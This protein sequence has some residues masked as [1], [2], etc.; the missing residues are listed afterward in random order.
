MTSD[1]TKHKAKTSHFVGIQNIT[2]IKNKSWFFHFVLLNSFERSPPLQ[3][4]IENQ[5][6]LELRLV[7][8]VNRLQISRK[9]WV[10]Q[11]TIRRPPDAVELVAAGQRQL[12]PWEADAAR[13]IHRRL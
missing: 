6:N 5:L 2:S 10:A 7:D 1:R 9:L 8:V 4:E 11:C 13:G 12:G 3:E